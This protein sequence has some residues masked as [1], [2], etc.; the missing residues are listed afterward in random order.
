MHPEQV[1]SFVRHETLES[2]VAVCNKSDV[3]QI[4]CMATYNFY[5]FNMNQ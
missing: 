4:T 1:A 5:T 2:E 3:T